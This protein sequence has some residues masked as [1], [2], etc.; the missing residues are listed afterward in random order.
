[1]NFANRK[2]L[3]TGAG[4]GIGRATAQAFAARGAHVIVTDV[5]AET[6]E[7]TAELIANAG[8]SYETHAVDVSDAIA[9]QAVADTV[10]ARHG[11]LDVLVNNAGIATVGR[12]L[13]TKSETWDRVWSVNVKGVMLGCQAFLPSMVARRSGHVV[14]LSSLA[15]YLASPDMAIYATSKYAVL[16][17]SEA[18][19]ADLQQHGIGVS[20]ICPGIVNTGIIAATTFEGRSASAQAGANR[21][22]Q[23]RNYPPSKVADAIVRAV[24]K[25]QA[26]VP[27]TPEA[28]IVYHLKRLVPSAARAIAAKPLPFMKTH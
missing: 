13:E 27:V 5:G 9:M 12:F 24:E 14:N 25:N 28:W 6:L 10:H 7:V 18:L 3:V 20:A 21:F 19:R 11:A 16:G 8:G 26:V 17:F 15:G 1:M 22:Y 2:V 4:G 23:R